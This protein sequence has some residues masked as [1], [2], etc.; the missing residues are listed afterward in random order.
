M[1]TL[2]SLDRK[3]RVGEELHSVVGTMKGLAAVAIHDYER[4]MAALREYTSSVERGL[5][6]VLFDRPES[7]P[8]DLP[9]RG[10]VAMIVIGTDQGLCGPINREIAATARDW[11]EEHRLDPDQRLVVALGV[12]AAR[13]LELLGMP[14]SEHE[15]LPGSVDGISRV[16]DDLILRID[17]WRTAGDVDRVLVFFQHPLQRTRR[18]PRMFQVLP[19]DANR[20]R[21][22][23]G[24][25]WPTRMLP[26]FPHDRAE[27]LS[28]LLREDLFVALYRA[29]AEAKTAEHG[30]RLSAMQAAE[31][32]IEDRIADLRVA[33]HQLRQA[34]ITEEILDVV[35]GFEAFEDS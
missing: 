16:V 34:K 18:T 12:R 26:A 31:Q 17:R 35:S 7:V 4:A 29:V 6:I 23:A 10:R 28:A 13:E 8:E 25:P 15:D 5:Q 20:L 14:P 19:P 1:A 3:L 21:R 30:A 32:N 9:D 27:L 2:G 11:G 33:Y 22:I 24:R